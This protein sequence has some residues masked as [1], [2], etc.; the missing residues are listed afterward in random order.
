MANDVAQVWRV[1]SL[2]DGTTSMEQLAVPLNEERTGR[3]SKLFDGPGVM[4]RRSAP[5][6]AA[7]WHT[8]PRRQM[9]ATLSGW[10]E[11][12]TGDG[13]R[14]RL[15]PGVL[16]VVEDVTG[17]GHQTWTDPAEGWQ[18][19]FIPLDDATTLA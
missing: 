17:V 1:F 11:I 9:I 8:A 14:L 10:G 13:Q 12:E 6:R 3:A 16:V 5:G 2:E 4:I 18:M 19:L 15:T 7:S